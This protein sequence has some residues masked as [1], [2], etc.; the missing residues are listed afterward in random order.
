MSLGP[1][2]RTVVHNAVKKERC[3]HHAVPARRPSQVQDKQVVG[4]E[5]GGA[6][7]ALPQGWRQT[8]ADTKTAARSVKQ[9]RRACMTTILP[10]AV[11][12]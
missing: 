5:P 7:A 2:R 3:A 9:G 4:G 8:Q 10:T 6:D 12:A 1:Y 11:A